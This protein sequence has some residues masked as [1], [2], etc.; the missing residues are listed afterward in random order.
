VVV[1]ENVP[2]DLGDDPGDD[3]G[4]LVGVVEPNVLDCRRGQRGLQRGS[5]VLM[6]GDLGHEGWDLKGD[7]AHDHKVPAAGPGAYDALPKRYRT[8][9]I[10]GAVDLAITARQSLVEGE[11]GAAIT[12]GDSRAMG[13]RP[14]MGSRPSNL[15]DVTSEIDPDDPRWTLVPATLTITVPDGTDMEELGHQLVNAV[16]AA[17]ATEDELGPARPLTLTLWQLRLQPVIVAEVMARAERARRLG[18]MDGREIAHYSLLLAALRLDEPEG[19]AGLDT[20]ARVKRAVDIVLGRP[21]DPLLQAVVKPISERELLEI[22]SGMIAY[23]RPSPRTD[24]A[25]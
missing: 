14:R 22:Q 4:E 1:R 24:P 21:V 16:C 2:V 20:L 5:A 23:F 12:G 17:S 8:G 3:V 25:E 15:G 19:W 13:I 9:G 18:V 11:Y 10:L 6:F 7:A